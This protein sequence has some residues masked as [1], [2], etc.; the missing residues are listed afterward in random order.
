MPALWLGVLMFLGWA[1]GACVLAWF[2]WRRHNWARWLLATSAAAAFVAGL[3]A[4]PVGLLNQLA[5]ALTIV[6][7][8]LSTSRTWFEQ[9]TWNTWQGPPSGPPSGYPPP[10]VPRPGPA[11]Q[12]QPPQDQPP[13]DQPPQDPPRGGR[14]PVW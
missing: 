7:L 4:F 14:P 9:D 12:D 10:R 1:L 11:A 6:G 2:T 5:A 8:F 3:F 13:Q